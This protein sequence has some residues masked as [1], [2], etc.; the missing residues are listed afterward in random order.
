[1]KCIFPSEEGCRSPSITLPSRSVTSSISGVMRPLLTPEGVISRAKGYLKELERSGVA[2]PA[3]SPAGEEQIS[4]SDI[5][6]DEVRD[7]L[8]E[9]DLNTLT[10]IEAMNLLFELQKK[11]RA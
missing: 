2:A 8:R 9:T 4:L 3:V 6:A 7:I 5:G 1:M 10:P 11:A